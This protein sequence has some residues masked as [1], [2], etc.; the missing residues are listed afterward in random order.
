M[1]SGTTSFWRVLVPFMLICLAGRLA[2]QVDTARIIGSVKDPS[3]GAV[4]GASVLFTNV[5]TNVGAAARADAAGRFESVPLRIGKYRVTVEHPGFKRAI[6]E[7]ILLQIQETAVVDVVLE[8]GAVTQ[9]VSVVAAAALLAVTEATQT[10]VIDNQKI[11]DLPL[12]GRNYIQLALLSAGASEPGNGAR[13]GGFSGSGMRASLNNYILDGMDNNNRQLASAGRQAET[14]RPSVDAI[15]EFKVMTNS[16]SAEYGRAAGAVVNVGIKSGTNS[17]HGSLFEFLRNEALDAKNFFDR[18][19]QP[20]PPFKRN[21]FGWSAGGPIRKDKTFFFGDYEWNRI[22]ESR[23]ANS[24]IPSMKMRDGDFSEAPTNRIYDPDTL[25]NGER[26]A[27]PGNAIPKSRLDPVGA[28]LISWYPTTNKPG[29][30][31][32]YLSNPPSREDVDRWDA[33]VDHTIGPRDNFYGRFSSQTDIVPASPTLPPPAWGGG[34]TGAEFNHYGRN[35]GLAYNRIFSPTLILSARAGWN[36]LYTNRFTPAP[37]NMN[38]EIGLRGVGTTLP[39]SALFNVNNYVALGNGQFNPNY[40]DSQ[41]RQL[42]ADLTWIRGG[43][44][45]KFGVNFGW[46][47]MY[48]NNAASVNGQFA[49]DGSFTRNPRTAREG[50]PVADLLLGAAVSGQVSNIAYMNQ[51]APWYDFYVQEEWKASPRLTLNI[52]VR[53]ELRLP[54]VETRN[55]WAN[56][57]IDTKPGT[58]QLVYARNGSRLDRATIR[59]DSNNFGPRFGFAWQPARHTVVRGGYGIYY[60][61]FQPFGD[62]Q[63]LHGNPPFQLTANLTTDSL[64]PTILLRNGLPAD[65]LDLRKARDVVTATYDRNGVLPYTQQWSFSI[66]RQ[67]PGEILLETGYYA[68][69][70]HKLLQRMEGN[71]APPGP[72]NINARRRFRSTFVPAV[73]GE[74]TL[75]TSSRHQ[76]SANANFQSLQVRVEKRLTHGLSVLSSYVW[77]KT[78]SD[79]RGVSPDG[80]ASANVPQNPQNLR[81]E[82]SLADEHIPHRFVVSEIWELPFG[83][84]RRFLSNAHPVIQF[85]AGG[86]TVA[87]ITTME[88]G[89]RVNTGVRGNPSNTGDANRPN[90]VHDWLLPAGQRSLQRWFDTTAFEINAP[91]TFGNAARNLIEGPGMVNFDLALYKSFRITE[92]KRLQFRTEAF[93]GFNTPRFGDPNAQAGNPNI[94]VISSAGRP[95]NLQFGLKLVF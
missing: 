46:M 83:S 85:L 21:Q 56:F 58:A 3:G 24:T 2:A 82:R 75:G 55:G 41:T 94:G 4:A 17:L 6:R 81:A 33:K 8:L 90:A 72:G 61:G 10:Q 37:T 5:E 80:G 71:W 47:Q 87:D 28:K 39:G 34:P 45:L 35:L 15:Q 91:Y 79:A 19:E 13:V 63:Y 76:W 93:N 52:G 12:N 62:T 88:S 7:G 74:V 18:P 77:S 49:F 27:F 40:S 65:A 59:T 92:T 32:N 42:V 67:L 29:L 73:N 86:W 14:I 68:N 66:Q 53:Y 16:F 11:V 31:N 36:Q 51:R 69:V 1:K 48:E 89:G 60:P 9:E 26:Q 38:R 30:V 64:L 44:T 84:G 78:I 23:T 25:A 50:N 22:R 43:H 95:R 70:A 57:D 54:F 20:K